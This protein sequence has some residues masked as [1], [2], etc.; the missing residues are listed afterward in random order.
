MRWTLVEH[1]GSVPPEQLRA[2]LAVMRPFTEVAVGVPQTHQGREHLEV[3]EVR[4]YGVVVGA[5]GTDQLAGGTLERQFLEGPVVALA[6]RARVYSRA[7]AV[8]VAIR[9]RVVAVLQATSE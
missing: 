9:E 1:K 3:L 2:V 7:V 6:R 4:V 5:P 8:L